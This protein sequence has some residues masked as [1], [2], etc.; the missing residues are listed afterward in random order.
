MPKI[1]IIL[2]ALLLLNCEEKQEPVPECD[3]MC[4]L[5]REKFKNSTAK[6]VFRTNNYWH[7]IYRVSV[8]RTATGAIANY[9]LLGG[10]N[11]KDLEVELSTE[12]WL[13]FI[14]A[15]SKCDIDKWENEYDRSSPTHSG[16]SISYSGWGLYIYSL[17]QN[18]NTREPYKADP[19]KKK[20]LGYKEHPPNWDKFEKVFDDMAAKIVKKV[21][22]PLEAKLKAEYPKKYGEHI[23]D[24]ELSTEKIYLNQNYGRFYA[25]DFYLVIS[26]TDTGAIAKYIPDKLKLEL[27][28]GEWLDFIRVLRKLRVNEWEKKYGDIVGSTDKWMLEI[29]PSDGEEPDKFEFYDA[30]PLNWAEFTKVIDDMVEKIKARA[31]NK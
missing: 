3:A 8:T 29:Y 6:V 4:E 28:I 1:L 31:G 9:V 22:A 18:Y 24:F 25:P 20:Y 13:D 12:E 15:L 19:P 11:P 10:N 7:D 17:D 21:N 14:E 2:F 27:G 26:R 23:S 5:L 30:Y 16:P